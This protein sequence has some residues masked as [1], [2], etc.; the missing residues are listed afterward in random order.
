MNKAGKFLAVILLMSIAFHMYYDVAV[1]LNMADEGKK[2]EL[3]GNYFSSKSIRLGFHFYIT[4]VHDFVIHNAAGYFNL[5]NEF[6][7]N[8]SFA[9]ILFHTDAGSSC[10]HPPQS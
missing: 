4:H 9:R 2:T 5:T 6:A 10:W 3:S 1:Q 7:I 8:Q